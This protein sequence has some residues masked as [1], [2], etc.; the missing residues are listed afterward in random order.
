M[1]C[2]YI[3]NVVHGLIKLQGLFRLKQLKLVEKTK[4]R[5]IVRLPKLVYLI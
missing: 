2:L 3:A 1:K 4:V 5:L